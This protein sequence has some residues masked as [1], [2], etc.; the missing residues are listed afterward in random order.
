MDLSKLQNGSDVRG[1]ALAGVENEPVTLDDAAVRAIAGGFA[2]FL[3]AR[4]GKESCRV[5]VGR[6][7]RLSGGAIAET[8]CET[9]AACGAD[10]VGQGG[11]RYGLAADDGDVAGDGR[12]LGQGLIQ[13]LGALA[14]IQR[15]EPQLGGV[16]LGV[17]TVVARHMG[18]DLAQ[19]T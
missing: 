18:M 6:D 8:L 1:V 12:K 4:L 14:F 16:Q 13:G 9:L 3:R 17:H 7:S 19:D 5:S 10:A 11:D 2:R 15:V